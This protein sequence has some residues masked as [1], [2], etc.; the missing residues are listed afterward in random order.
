GAGRYEKEALD[1]VSGE[2]L[3][4]ATFIERECAAGYL[5]VLD[6]VAEQDGLPWNLYVDHHGSLARND[7]HWSAEEQSAGV[8]QPTHVGRALAA[9]HINA[10][11]ALSPQAKG[12]VER[13][14]CVGNFVFEP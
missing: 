14:E 11:Y 10:I 1:G 4:G 12:R 3:A 7:D 2:V 6:A 9:L 5:N 8:Q 13:L